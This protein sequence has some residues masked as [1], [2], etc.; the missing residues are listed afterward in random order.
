MEQPNSPMLLSSAPI[1][2]RQCLFIDNMHGMIK[3]HPGNQIQPTTSTSGVVN[4]TFKLK[5][6]QLPLP[7]SQVGSFTAPTLI[8]EGSSLEHELANCSITS[9]VSPTNLGYPVTSDHTHKNDHLTAFKGLVESIYNSRAG[10]GGAGRGGGGDVNLTPERL[11]DFFTKFDEHF[12]HNGETE[13]KSYYGKRAESDN[14]AD[15]MYDTHTAYRDYSMRMS[16]ADMLQKFSDFQSIAS[17]NREARIQWNTHPNFMADKLLAPEAPY[18]NIVLFFPGLTIDALRA[19]STSDKKYEERKSYIKQLSEMVSIQEDQIGGDG[20][21]G[22]VGLL[23]TF[24][25]TNPQY[26]PLHSISQWISNIRNAVIKTYGLSFCKEY[27]QDICFIDMSCTTFYLLEEDIIPG[28]SNTGLRHQPTILISYSKNAA[29]RGGAG[30]AVITLF[31]GDSD[32]NMWKRLQDMKSGNHERKRARTADEPDYLK[33]FRYVFVDSSLLNFVPSGMFHDIFE[34][35]SVSVISDSVGS[36][37]VLGSDTPIEIF[38]DDD[39]DDA[40]AD[41]DGADAGGAGAD[42]E[43]AYLASSGGTRR[44]HSRS[45]RCRYMIRQKNKTTRCKNKVRMMK[46]THLHYGRHSGR[47][48]RRGRRC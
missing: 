47:R 33:Q 31:V 37:G 38:K 7:L 39:G 3:L 1:T 12:F 48:G 13:L 36:T 4:N 43:H 34:Q 27:M 24:T 19:M 22:P 32:T 41:G 8:P 11:A 29:D 42:A 16:G 17:I 30:D 23:L 18:N 2:R 28:T 5:P 6:I 14:R 25:F 20:G 21:G 46:K 9:F 44:T 45:R 10:G 15:K 40:D 26:M 35:P